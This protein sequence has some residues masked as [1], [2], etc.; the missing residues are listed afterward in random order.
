MVGDVRFERTK[1]HEAFACFQDKLV[2]PC[3]HNLRWFRQLDSDQCIPG[4][5][6][7]A[8][9]TW[10]CRNMVGTI[11]IKLM[12]FAAREQRSITELSPNKEVRADWLQSYYDKVAALDRATG[13][14]LAAE[15]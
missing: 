15:Y 4:S 14:T 7:G 9:P 8:L 2:K 1:R 3:S 12:T 13:L 5:G 11:R 6:P 10:L